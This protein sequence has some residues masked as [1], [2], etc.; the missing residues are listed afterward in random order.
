MIELREINEENFDECVCLEMKDGQDAYCARNVYSLAQAWL[1]PEARPFCIYKDDT[2]VGFVMLDYDEDE[3]ECGIWR[4]MIDKKYQSMGYG[5]EAMRVVLEYI[6][7]NPV[8]NVVHLSTAPNN[9]IAIKLY[10]SFGFLPTGE[11]DDDGEITMALE[12]G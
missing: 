11:I 8:F 4:F 2:M 9:E 6:K 7:S 12:L 1:Y 3:K 5:K 10:K